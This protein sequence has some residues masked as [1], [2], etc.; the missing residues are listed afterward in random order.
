MFLYIRYM[1]GLEKVQ[2]LK[3]S[4]AEYKILIYNVSKSQPLISYILGDMIPPS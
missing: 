3:L 4:Q 1:S 2:E